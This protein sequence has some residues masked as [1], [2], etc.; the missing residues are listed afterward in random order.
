MSN[1]NNEHVHDTVI[2]SSRSLTAA[3]DPIVLWRCEP[4]RIS[5][6]PVVTHSLSVRAC[7]RVATQRHK[8]REAQGDRA[9]GGVAASDA[10]SHLTTV[11]SPH[12]PSA[13]LAYAA[14][15]LSPQPL[16]APWSRAEHTAGTPTGM[17]DASWADR[18]ASPR[19]TRD[20]T[21]LEYATQWEMTAG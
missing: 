21:Q 17:S 4:T 1:A 13:S 2:L 6:S 19:R 3:S 11:G 14:A 9:R 20:L 16:Q 7:P 8:R 10:G 12:M 15:A 5:Q 18:T